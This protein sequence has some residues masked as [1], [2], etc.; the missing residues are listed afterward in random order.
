MD[1]PSDR[2][3]ISVARPRALFE[4]ADRLSSDLAEVEAEVRPE[5]AML[6][7]AFARFLRLEVANGDAT[8]DT[9][10][11]YRA[12]VGLWVEWC[13]CNELDPATAG[14]DEVKRYRQHLVD[15][16]L[17]PTTIA[18]KLAILRRFYAAIQAT[19]LRP[20]NPAVGIRPP[21][22]KKAPE[23]FGYLSEIELTLLFRSAPALDSEAALRDRALLALLGLQG[24]RTVEIERANV[25]DLRR[26]GDDWAL[27]VRGKY[28][29]RLVYL[30][31]D[32]ADAL[33]SYL[34][35]RAS[36]ITDEQGT[37]LFT[38]VG[39]RAGGNRISRRG[40]RFT[41]DRHLRQAGLKRAGVSD[42]AL[43]HT[44]A[45]LAYRYS[46]DLRAVQDLLGHRDPRTTSRYAR[47]VDMA[48]TN[49]VLKVPVK[50][51]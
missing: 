20:D 18:N 17:Q 12:Q 13:A 42:H 38:A 14:P 48:T 47:V 49:P 44:A 37:P 19:G 6:D 3:R 39:N 35:V 28:H 23:D 36:P 16:G 4:P 32:V 51:S 9:I 43:R 1:L 8:P 10:R 33:N 34:E 40:V 29:D 41:V 11:S 24:L 27:L 46:R 25:D 22:A 26:R 45:T 15:T 50:L 30:R 7:A 31:A 2:S 5:S 21:G